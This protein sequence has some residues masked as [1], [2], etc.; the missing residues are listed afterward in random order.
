MIIKDFISY[1]SVQRRYSPRTCILYEEALGDF[2][3]YF[4]NEVSGGDE[5]LSC[6]TTS[7]IRNYIAH[8]LDIGLNPRTVNLRLSAMSSFCN[9]LVKQSLLASNPVKKITRPKEGKRLPSFYTERALEEYFDKYSLQKEDK[10][11]HNY[12]NRMVMLILYSTGIRRAELVNLKVTDF[13]LSRGVV[14]V[15]GKGDKEREIPIPS[16]V[17]QE[18]ILYLKRIKVEFPEGTIQYFI[19]NDEGLQIKPE[20]VNEVVHQEL[21]GLEG[22]SG[23]KSPHVL[24]HSLATHLL[25]N[26]ADLNSIK[27]VLGHSSLA[28]TQVYTHNSFEQLKKVYLT[29]HP[30]AKNGGKNGN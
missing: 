6:L 9:Y 19:V 10:N 28:A 20:F 18:I 17:I 15:L 1:I 5:I 11:F 8:C 2:F 13:D 29:A 4:S 7:N 21:D 30:R 26:G 16:S 23:K 3:N 22:F 24:R 25:N 27:E 14:R 12:R